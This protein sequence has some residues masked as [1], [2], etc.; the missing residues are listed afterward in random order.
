MKRICLLLV[1]LYWAYGSLNPL[2]AQWVQ[3]SLD[4]GFIGSFAVNGAYLFAGSA[5]GFGTFLSTDSGTSWT[6]ANAGL[7][8]TS[9]TALAASPAGGGTNLFAGTQGSGI[10][11]STNDGT[12]WTQTGLTKINVWSLASF[13]TNLFAGTELGGVLLSTN[14]GTS[15][16]QT[17]L[18]NTGVWSL[19]VSPT[20]S[21]GSVNL[22]AGTDGSGVFL[23]TNNGR[24]WTQ[25]GLTN[26]SVWSLAVCGIDLFAGTENGGGVYLSTNNGASWTAVNNK[27]PKEHDDTTVYAFVNALAM[28]V[29][30]LF[31]G[32]D[33][34]GIYLSTKSDASW[35]SVNDGFPKMLDDSTRCLPVHA[36]QVYGR[37][38]FAGTEN[39]GVWRRP[40]SEMI[41]SVENRSADMPMHFSLDQN[42]PNP[43]NPTTMIRF[44]LP[45]PE[46]V[47]LKLYDILGQEI[48]TLISRNLQAGTHAASWNAGRYPSGVYFY[49]LQASSFSQTRKLLLLR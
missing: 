26:P 24:S 37:N 38:L 30:D 19:A 36:L 11:L 45:H 10:F 34:G 18:T 39:G 43:F 9:V 31:A 41:T 5:D 7:S 12:S 6:Q 28:S 16:T 33:F 17:G 42:Y 27:L 13:D 21:S 49:S 20:D 40:L 15:W 8:N 35:I 32:T 4:S 47:S 1:G 14:H 44:S 2:F 46:F 3:T 23:S 25:T 29:S 48:A 22:F